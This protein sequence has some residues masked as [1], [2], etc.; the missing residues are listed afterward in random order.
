MPHSPLS[1]LTYL[2]TWSIGL[3][4]QICGNMVRI[5]KCNSVSDVNI[6]LVDEET[7]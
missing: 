4:T 7:N 1:L 3:V 5:Q 2:P 6:V